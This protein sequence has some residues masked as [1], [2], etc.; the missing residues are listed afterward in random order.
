MARKQTVEPDVTSADADAN[1]TKA[2][3]YGINRFTLLGRMTAD[4]QVR[5][6]HNGKALLR[7]GLATTVNGSL[8]FHDLVAWER[9]AETLGEYGHKGRELFVEGRISS[10]V[11]EVEGHRIKQIDLVVDSFQ[12]LG[13]PGTARNGNNESGSERLA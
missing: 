7:F 8:A 13:S 6:T 1:P 12:L 3:S 4:P 9:G 5:F 11:R 10:R 2:R